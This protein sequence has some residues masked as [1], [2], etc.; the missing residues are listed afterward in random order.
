M[1][2]KNRRTRNK[3]IR[4]VERRV[5]NKRTTREDVK[6]SRKQRRTNRKQRRT[7]RKQRR[8]NRKQRRTNRKQRRVKRELYGGTNPAGD[9][10]PPDAIAPSPAPVPA[11]SETVPSS[12][13]VADVDGEGAEGEVGASG[14]EGEVDASGESPVDGVGATEVPPSNDEVAAEGSGVNL[15]RANLVR[16]KIEKFQGAEAEKIEEVK[17]DAANND[18]NKDISF[19]KIEDLIRQM[20]DDKDCSIEPKLENFQTYEQIRDRTEGK[21]N[22]LKNMAATVMRDVTQ[23]KNLYTI[24]KEY[25]KFRKKVYDY[26]ATDTIKDKTIMEHYSKYIRDQKKKET[27]DG[28]A[29]QPPD[30]IWDCLKNLVA[31]ADD[32]DFLPWDVNRRYII[33]PKFKT[34]NLRDKLLTINH[35]DRDGTKTDLKEELNELNGKYKKKVS[36]LKGKIVNPNKKWEE[37]AQLTVG[38]DNMEAVKVFYNE[39]KTKIE[40][41]CVSVN[42]WV[43]SY[44]KQGMK[45]QNF[46]V[47]L[48]DTLQGKYA[49]DLDIDDFGGFIQSLM[50][51]LN[52]GELTNIVETTPV[53]ATQQ[54]PS[55]PVSPRPEDAGSRGEGQEDAERGRED[56]EEGARQQAE[57]DEEEEE[58]REIEEVM[59][60][61]AA[62]DRRARKFRGTVRAVTAAAPEGRRWRNLPLPPK[63]GQLPPVKPPGGPPLGT[64]PG[65]PPLTPPPRD[66]YDGEAPEVIDN[67]GSPLDVEVLPQPTGART[68]AP[69]LSTMER[70]S[71]E[72]PLGADPGPV[73]QTPGPARKPQPSLR[74]PPAGAVSLADAAAETD[75]PGGFAGTEKVQNLAAG[76]EDSVRVEG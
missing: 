50:E 8:T 47:R 12:T 74:P 58:E 69:P 44:I 4:K 54:S 35:Q 57:D 20:M 26:L 5:R 13:Q 23:R 39:L 60:R 52:K 25:N 6:S 70:T 40:D 14:D 67:A 48:M 51:L 18:L 42:E 31:F 11:T 9:T 62:R 59:A 49:K 1:T 17:A 43:L 68:A 38:E 36:E 2:R 27:Q 24:E 16:E 55:D 61:A 72:E 41:C 21:L 37:Q 34:R 65:P 46:G 10:P 73:D 53:A 66:Q 3:S 32:P 64:Q 75:V 76:E 7:N 56:E 29:Q 33:I 15:P 63:P 71:S 30:A 45:I 22:A 28:D 19:K